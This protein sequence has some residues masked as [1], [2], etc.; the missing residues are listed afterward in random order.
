LPT[1]ELGV[2]WIDRLQHLTP[3]VLRPLIDL[4]SLL[5]GPAGW[6]LVVALCFWWSGSRL[7][8]RVATV[9]ATSSLLNVLLKWLFASPR[10]FLVHD[11]VTALIVSDGFGFP[12]GHAQGAAAQWGAVV[13]GVAA[14]PWLTAVAAVIVAMA[15]LCRIYYGVHTPW[16]VVVGWTVGA[17]LALAGCR[18]G[19]RLRL[20]LVGLRLRTLGG[21]STFI[22]VV[23]ALAGRA[24]ASRVERAGLPTA[25]WSERFAA[26]ASRL[27]DPQVLVLVDAGDLWRAIG[28]SIGALSVAWW[29]GRHEEE[30][31]CGAEAGLA[32]TCVGS[33]ALAAALAAG[34]ILVG[35]V[36]P[37]GELLRY[38]S[39]AWIV[40]VLTPA[41]C[42]RRSAERARSSAR[43]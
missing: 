28:S 32:R 36:G 13:S 16:Q 33:L 7:G 9:T 42:R 31:V 37:A 19:G 20:W 8:V 4:F 41:V 5:G 15:G 12:S 1:G 3:P 40:G 22:V 17:A 43:A 11:G 25:D 10:P 2:A 26:T 38:G 30:R 14:A 24:L 29:L 18:L 35:A 34:S 21:L 27:G 6:L 39:L 23:A